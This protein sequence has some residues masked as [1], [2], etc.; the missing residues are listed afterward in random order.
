M[1]L[2]GQGSFYEH[3]RGRLVLYIPADVRKDSCFPFSPGEKVKVRIKGR[4]L[5]VEKES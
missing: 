4:T 5:I 2:E 1:T 3:A